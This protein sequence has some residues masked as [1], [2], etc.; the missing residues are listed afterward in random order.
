M[1]EQTSGSWTNYRT[2]TDLSS[3]TVSLGPVP[4]GRFI[5][6]LIIH[7]ATAAD[8]GVLNIT[9]VL[10]ETSS[11]NEE[12]IRHAYD[13]IHSSDFIIKEAKSA[14]MNFASGSTQD[15]EIPVGIRVQ[16]QSVWCL[17]RY[18]GDGVLVRFDILSSL[19]V[20]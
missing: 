6:A 8:G 10:T 4:P 17:I 15:I 14:T 11:L 1:A 12:D 19:R 13:I 9:P 5:D 18:E 2:F 7:A 16:G 20:F 3:H